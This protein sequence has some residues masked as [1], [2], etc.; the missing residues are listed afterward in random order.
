MSSRTHTHPFPRRR[1]SGKFHDLPHAKALPNTRD[2]AC[3]PFANLRAPCSHQA[4]EVGGVPPPQQV[5]AIPR[6]SRPGGAGW[7]VRRRQQPSLSPLQLRST[8]HQTCNKQQRCVSHG[9]QSTRTMDRFSEDRFGPFS[10]LSSV[11]R[12]GESTPGRSRSTDQQP[13]SAHDCLYGLKRTQ[14]IT[15]WV[16]GRLDRMEQRE[17]SGLD[18][19][20]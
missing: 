16:D 19:A 3:S 14:R 4:A 15:W 18:V 20:W 2:R 12:I 7:M 17:I 6:P 1:D 9:I 13:G 5:G 10:L 8:Q 11:P